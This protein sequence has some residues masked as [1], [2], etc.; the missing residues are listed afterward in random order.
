MLGSSSIIVASIIINHRR[1]HCR[2]YRY[3][4]Y[5]LI[6]FIPL[7]E[8]FS[9]FEQTTDNKPTEETLTVGA[10]SQSIQGSHV[11]VTNSTDI[12][13]ESRTRLISRQSHELEWFVCFHGTGCRWGFGR[14]PN[15]RVVLYAQTNLILTV[16]RFEKSHRH[17]PSQKQNLQPFECIYFNILTTCSWY[18]IT[19]CSCWCRFERSHV[20]CSMPHV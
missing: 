1:H 8:M 13:S 10:Y 4:N 16:Q 17:L 2:W 6:L 19:D 9:Q 12:T 18:V 14:H 3:H 11:K 15:I 20:Q 7:F 5:I